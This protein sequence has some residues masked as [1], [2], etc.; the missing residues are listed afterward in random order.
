MNTVFVLQHSHFLPSGEESVKFI[1]IYRTA[2]AAIAA[3][4]RLADQPG[5]ARH[6]TIIDSDKT[7]DEE[8]F[9]IDE[10]ELDK[11]HWT[12]GFVTLIGD[13]EYRG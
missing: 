9:Y 8:G 13:E 12:E 10:Y 2:E 3:A 1:G 6:P 5:F 11:D 4:K 7:D